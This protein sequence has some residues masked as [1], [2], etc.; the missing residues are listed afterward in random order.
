M[1]SEEQKRCA[2]ISMMNSEAKIGVRMDVNNKAGAAERLCS[3]VL[4]IILLFIFAFSLS[5]LSVFYAIED[6]GAIGT[7]IGYSLNAA[8]YTFFFGR[9]QTLGMMAMKLKLCS[10]DGKYPIGYG[11]GFLRWIGLFISGIVLIGYLWIL[12]DEKKQGWHDKIA[13]TYVVKSS[14]NDTTV[15]VEKGSDTVEEEKIGVVKIVDA[16]IGMV[17]HND[18]IITSKRMIFANT[19]RDFLSN[20]LGVALFAGIINFGY[21]GLK[22][23]GFGIPGGFT[24]VNVII[25]IGIL[26]TL[27]TRG[28]RAEKKSEE[29]NILPPDDILRDHRRNFEIPY[30][31]LIKVEISKSEHNPL[32]KVLMDKGWK[33]IGY[34]DKEICPDYLD[35][36]RAALSDKEVMVK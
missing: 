3:F 7:L 9:G 28:E 33:K 6:M 4:D 30:S 35:I 20:P 12:F 8:Y 21:I 5:N 32:I 23:M 2:G 11:R 10:T 27:S 24:I 1:M 14:L 16:G 34:I 18:L 31:T 19:C 26:F 22:F 13:G 15:Q 29:L 36:I 17:A 25:A